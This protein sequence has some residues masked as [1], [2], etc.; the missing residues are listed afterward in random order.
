[1]AHEDSQG[2]LVA[3]T[4][5][6]YFCVGAW[7]KLDLQ[8]S[9]LGSSP[10]SLLLLFQWATNSFCYQE[11]STY[12]RAERENWPFFFSSFSWAFVGLATKA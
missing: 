3:A 11:T 8:L 2:E 1:M 7:E 4:H 9:D 10:V 6:R 12:C 5:S